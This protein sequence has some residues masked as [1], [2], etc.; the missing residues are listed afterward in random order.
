[1]GMTDRWEANP[2]R[3]RWKEPGKRAVGCEG[4]PPAGS[5]GPAG[6]FSLAYSVRNIPPAHEDRDGKRLRLEGLRV[7]QIT[8]FLATSSPFAFIMWMAHARHGSKECRVRSASRGR[9]GSETGFPTRDASYGPFCPLPSR[10]PAFH[11][12][13][14]TA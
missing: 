14:T 12:E 13:G 8:F 10:G 2:C 6:S 7:R 4:E 5:E 11:V 9:A 1:M 3:V